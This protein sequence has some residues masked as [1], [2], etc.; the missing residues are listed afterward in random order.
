M[1]ISSAAL[2]VLERVQIDGPHVLLPQQLARPLYLEV[3]KVLEAIGGAWNRR[4][5][6]H[7]FSIDPT[8]AL[9]QVVVDG[10]FLDVKKELNFFETPSPLA[11]ELVALAAIAP[12][13]RILEPSAG[14]G[15]IA[16]A[17]REAHPDCAL[18]I[19][20]IHDEFRR[21]LASEFTL[22]ADDFLAYRP[23]EDSLYDRIV[24]NPPFSRQRDIAHVSH[25]WECLA[26]GGHLVA[27]MA[28]GVEFRQ[29]AT[30]RAFRELVDQHG[31][32]ER[33]PEGT[34]AESGTNVCTVRVVLH[35]SAAACAARP[36]AV[37]PLAAPTRARRAR[38]V[39]A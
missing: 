10:A 12:R 14:R 21:S 5:R 13:H 3:N 1:Q 23:D 7:V 37:E 24:M 25:A 11:R 39:A 6:A 16:R 2:D 32:V 29:N 18:D 34:F 38:G 17:I 22:V 31:A 26:P 27:V 33:L 9:E 28:A 35:K 30:A 19:C 8:D 4:A 15:R 36:I 20:E